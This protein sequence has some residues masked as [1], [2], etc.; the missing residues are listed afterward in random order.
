MKIYII[1]QVGSGK[2]TL[3]KKLSQK[4]NIKYYEL[5]KVVWNDENGNTK[6]SK[7]E[8]LKLFNEIINQDSW[9]IEDVGR[10]IFKDS[11]EKCDKI[12]YLKHS[13]TTLYQ[14][15]IKRW[16][17]QLLKIE[18]SNYKP[19]IKTLIEMINWLDQGLKK[20]EEK[21]N[22]LKKYES[23]KLLTKTDIKKLT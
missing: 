6:R 12:Y 17:K 22:A 7:E 16:I 18:K 19:T 4:Y 14:R 20:E 11:Y 2:T 8:Q 3:A 21:I 5:D 9:I 10:E 15:I 23:F 13:K 1:G